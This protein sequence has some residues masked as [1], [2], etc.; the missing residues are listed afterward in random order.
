MDKELFLYLNSFYSDFWDTIMLMVTRKETWIPFYLTIVYYIVV[1]YRKKWILILLVMAVTILISDQLSVLIKESVQRL[2][3]VRDPSIG[4]VVH[5]FLRLGGY[6][7]FVSSHASNTFSIF[8]FTS[9]VFKNRS[10]YVLMFLWALLVSYSR[11]YT[12]VHFPLDIIGGAA[13]GWLLGWSMFRLLMYMED[14]LLVLGSSKI[15]KTALP[16]SSVG[17]ICLVFMVMA[18]S[19]TIMTYVLHHYHYL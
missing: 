12:G 2:R 4:H 6:Y 5:N 16:A 15:E 3:P 13:L 9:M 18:V 1:H 7:G 14:H 17:I 11:I 19:V 10:Y 8:V